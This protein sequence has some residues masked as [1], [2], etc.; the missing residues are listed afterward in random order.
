MKLL[1][2]SSEKIS[3]ERVVFS[4]QGSKNLF[5]KMENPAEKREREE[6]PPFADTERT[7]GWIRDWI[8]KDFPITF[9]PGEMHDFS[10][11]T[12]DWRGFSFAHP[13]HDEAELWCKKA[14]SESL[15]GNFS[16]L[17]LPAVFNSVYW[18]DVIYKGADEIH[19]LT[20]PV[21]KPGAKKQ[22]VSQM[23]LVVF[24]GREDRVPGQQPALFLVEPENW[25]DKYYKRKRNQARFSLRQ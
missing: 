19:I 10:P 15:K 11:L 5:W 12:Q 23:A 17:L 2:L 20:C 22:I 14:V 24:A 18:R 8:Y 3:T 7:P 21:K 13:P 9:E 16:V 6:I 4:V 1:S 25:E